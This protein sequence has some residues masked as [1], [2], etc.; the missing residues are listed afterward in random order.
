MIF[1]FISFFGPVSIMG[2]PKSKNR[3][4]TQNK[5][6]QLWCTFHYSIDINF[7][8][9]CAVYKKNGASH[10]REDCQGPFEAILEPKYLNLGKRNLFKQIGPFHL[11]PIMVPFLPAKNICSSSFLYTTVTYRCLHR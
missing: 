4:I 10:F 9:H 6:H 5:I 8:H 1:I 11:S 7:N 3:P 2:M